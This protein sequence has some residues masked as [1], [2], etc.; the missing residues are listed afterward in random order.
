MVASSPYQCLTLSLLIL[1]PLLLTT[2]F[3][4]AFPSPPPPIFIHPSLASLPPTANSWSIYPEDFYPGGGYASLPGGK[5]LVAIYD[6]YRAT[7]MC[8]YNCRFGTGWWDRRR[9]KRSV[10]LL[11]KL[12][13]AYGR[14]GCIDTRAIDTL[15][16][17]ERNRSYI[18][19]AWLSCFAL[20]F[21]LPF[22]IFIPVLLWLVR[23]LWQRLLW[24]A[25]HDIQYEPIH[26]TASSSYAISEMG[27]GQYRW[28]FH[29]TIFWQECFVYNALKSC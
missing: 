10:S 4:A 22:I 13:C 29:G 28:G 23:S 16:R 9:G 2:Y 25:S 11:R 18:G 5:V 3:M 12:V 7:L 15:H 19:C 27:E 21:V 17:L 26:D 6:R 20:W 8:S 14:I 24:R 1:P